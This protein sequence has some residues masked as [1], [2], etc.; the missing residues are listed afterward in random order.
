MNNLKFKVVGDR[1]NQ[2]RF[3]SRIITESLNEA[4]KSLG[5]YSDDS[6]TVVY[7]G[8][9][10]HHGYNPNAIICTYEITFPS[11]L[12]QN[13]NGKPILGVSRDNLNFITKSGYSPEKAG[14]FPLGVDSKLYPKIK[15]IK[16]LSQFTVGVYTESL[17]R[18]GVELCLQSFAKAFSGDADCKLLIKDRN[19]SEKFHQFVTHFSEKNNILVEYQNLHFSNISEITD[20]FSGVDCHLY[21]NRSSTWAMPPLE[22]MTMGVPTLAVAYSGPREY[23]FDEETGIEIPFSEESITVDF[24]ALAEIGCRNFFFLNGYSSQP[25]WAVGNTEKAAE[26]LI[27]LK[28]DKNLSNKISAQGREYA[29][30]N[31]SW[32]NSALKLQEQLARWHK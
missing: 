8:C 10:N 16:N 15:K 25:T 13:A 9:C 12:I 5:M 4:A 27:K 31:L 28:N 29:I 32:Q 18:G 24:P 19:G 21:M 17:I 1:N 22:S 6:L 2:S 20:W 30:K 11:I 7:D 14:Y 23:I 3:S 26:K